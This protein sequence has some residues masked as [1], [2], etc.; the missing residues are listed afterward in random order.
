MPNYP[1]CN[2]ACYLRKTNTLSR[3]RRLPKPNS[4]FFFHSSYAFIVH[5]KKNRISNANYCAN[6]GKTSFHV[7]IAIAPEWIMFFGSS[8]VFTC[9][10]TLEIPFIFAFFWYSRTFSNELKIDW[11]KNFA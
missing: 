8:T 3:N 11:N 1:I 9:I 4:N 5:V 7:Y 2:C 10:L 6:L